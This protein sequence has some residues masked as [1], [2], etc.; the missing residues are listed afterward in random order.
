ME[1]RKTETDRDRQTEIDTERGHIGEWSGIGRQQMEREG[2][3][4][5]W[6][7]VVW[8][9]RGNDTERPGNKD[10]LSPRAAHEAIRR[11]PTLR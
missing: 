1:D 7:T 2:I 9:G 5:G 11:L 3:G 4:G 8:V 6:G 10:S